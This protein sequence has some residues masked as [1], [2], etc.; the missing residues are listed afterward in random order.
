MTEVRR[1]LLLA[2]AALGCGRNGLPAGV[3]GSIDAPAVLD[4]SQ[5]AI[6]SDAPVDPPM[7]RPGP[8]IEPTGDGP[9]DVAVEE[10]C[11]A[12]CKLG[13]SYCLPDD[14]VRA[15]VEDT[16]CPGG[17]H[18]VD[19]LCP[20]GEAC[21]GAPPEALCCKPVP[22]CKGLT[23]FPSPA[24][25]GY[26]V[27]TCD[28]DMAGCPFSVPKETC[29]MV[30]SCQGLPGSVSCQCGGRAGI[31]YCSSVSYGT[32]CV[33]SKTKGE[34]STVDGCYGIRSTAD[35]DCVDAQ[36]CQGPM[37][38][39]FCGCPIDQTDPK[40]DPKTR[41]VAGTG[42]TAAER[43]STDPKVNTACDPMTG[44]IVRCKRVGAPATACD[45]WV[46]DPPCDGGMCTTDGK[47]ADGTPV[48]PPHC[49]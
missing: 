49:G 11:S 12:I 16:L 4:G 43:D 33:D 45:V 1:S 47:K 2:V 20:A 38:M 3:D 14:R 36:V 8:S 31:A 41:Y 34:C 22:E 25:K 9:A 30:R 6:P 40:F 19:S 35:E 28:K 24:C 44:R 37:G 23:A 26:D 17:T 46:A 21:T 39:A 27:V 29:S 48:S 18:F 32:F 13:D 5:D 42:C 15:C 10:P 7:D